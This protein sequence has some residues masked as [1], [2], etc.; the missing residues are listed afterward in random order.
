M[1]KNQGGMVVKDGV[2]GGVK[3]DGC[4]RCKFKIRII[5]IDDAVSKMRNMRCE[6]TR[7]T[8]KAK[9]AMIENGM[10]MSKFTLIMMF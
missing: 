9:K 6:L 10:G 5:I 7:S 2:K 3:D 8:P 4:V 1:E